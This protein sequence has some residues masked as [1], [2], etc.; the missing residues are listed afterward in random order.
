MVSRIFSKDLVS[1]GAKS[2]QYR[3][4]GDDVRDVFWLAPYDD[5]LS[6]GARQ[7]I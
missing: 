7:S 5:A 3:Q 1:G 4:S 6:Q 2:L